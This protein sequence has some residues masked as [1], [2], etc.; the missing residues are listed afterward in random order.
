MAST[1][2]S[3]CNL[4]KANIVFVCMSNMLE[5]F[6]FFSDVFIAHSAFKEWIKVLWWMCQIFFQYTSLLE[7]QN[8]VKEAS[9]G[10]SKDNIIKALFLWMWLSS[11]SL[12]KPYK[13]VFWVQWLHAVCILGV[14]TERLAAW[15]SVFFKFGWYLEF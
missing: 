5:R 13:A 11:R 12:V 7:M 10:I 3:P 9:Q 14:H 4:Y 6:V 2:K 8:I 1:R 15:F